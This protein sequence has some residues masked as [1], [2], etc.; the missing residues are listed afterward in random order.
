MNRHEEIQFS[1]SMSV[2][3]VKG[4]VVLFVLLSKTDK[5]PELVSFIVINIYFRKKVK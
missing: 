3:T 5:S 4:H 1:R 2:D